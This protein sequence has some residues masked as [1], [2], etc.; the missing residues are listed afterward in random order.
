MPGATRLTELA[1]WRSGVPMRQDC[2]SRRVECPS[3]RH[4][5]TT[6]GRN[7]FR[8]GVDEMD[9]LF[10]AFLKRRKGGSFWLFMRL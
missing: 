3:N 10:Q 5:K 4:L 1:A 9:V 7:L 6:Q 2:R 8:A